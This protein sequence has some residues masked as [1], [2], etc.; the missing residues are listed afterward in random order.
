MEEYPVGIDLTV[1][2]L[3]ST[4]HPSRSKKEK[5]AGKQEVVLMLTALLE[6]QKTKLCAEIP[7]IPITDIPEL[8]KVLRGHQEA[9]GPLKNDAGNPMVCKNELQPQHRSTSL[10]A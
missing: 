2:P 7:E 8:Q 10:S 1:L 6:D 5:Y 4:H 9:F 3:N